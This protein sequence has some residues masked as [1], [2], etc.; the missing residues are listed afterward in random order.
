MDAPM[1]NKLHVLTVPLVLA[2]LLLAVSAAHAAPVT[3]QITPLAFEEEFAA[4]EEGEEGEGEFEE[5]ACEEAE[6]EFEESELDAAEVGEI[7]EKEKSS[8]H[9]A[10]TR[11]QHGKTKHRHPHKK[12]CRHRAAAGKR[13]CPHRSH[14]R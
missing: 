1:P 11:P 12:A 9:Q 10:P 13:H 6:E 8:E 14:R 3:P 4:D 7:C 5:G 2:L